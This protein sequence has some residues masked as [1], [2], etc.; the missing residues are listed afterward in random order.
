MQCSSIKPATSHTIRGA[1]TS[2]TVDQLWGNDITKNH[3]EYEKGVTPY[4]GHLGKDL[5]RWNIQRHLIQHLVRGRQRCGEH[6]VCDAGCT[7]RTGGRMV[8]TI[9]TIGQSKLG[10]TSVIQ[11]MNRVMGTLKTDNVSHSKPPSIIMSLEPKE[12]TLKT[13]G[14]L[15]EVMLRVGRRH[16]P[17][18]GPN[19][20]LVP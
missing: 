4:G 2:L 6:H 7:K 16:E 10:R 19:I 17:L 11:E 5:N 14:E 18:A 13:T 9:G 3:I 8:C 20:T 12:C 1:A 15:G